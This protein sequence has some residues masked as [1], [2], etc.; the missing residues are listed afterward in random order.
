MTPRI[1]Q[2]SEQRVYELDFAG[3]LGAD[4]AEIVS[5]DIAPRGQVAQATALTAASSAFDGTL[6]RV[7]LAGG[8]S[9]ELYLVTV[10][11]ASAAGGPAEQDFEVL[12]EDLSWTVPD[13]TTAY[14][15]IEDFVTRLGIGDAL[16]LTDELGS[17]RINKP[18]IIAAILDAQAEVDSYLGKVYPVP[19]A[20]PVPQR[21]T[22]LVFDLAVAGLH[23]GALPAAVEQA[24]DRATRAL[25]DLANGTAVLTDIAV[26]TPTPAAT[27]TSGLAIE[28]A[29]RR[30]TRHSMRD[31]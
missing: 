7:E 3:D 24:R 8:T 25:R 16:K 21:V 9:G 23:T 4:V 20:A 22:R 13:G 26:A 11:A 2:P 18:V 29:P 12:V 30:F 6:V 15:S 19:L 1:K 10:Q 14:L 27:P 5:I 28:S 17:G 31:F